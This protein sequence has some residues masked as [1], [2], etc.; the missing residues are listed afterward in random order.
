MSYIELYLPYTLAE[1]LILRRS[2]GSASAKP[3][4]TPASRRSARNK[5]KSPSAAEDASGSVDSAKEGLIVRPPSKKLRT[6]DGE[7]MA[8]L[9]DAALQTGDAP[10]EAVDALEAVETPETVKEG[11]TVSV[12]V[13]IE[14][15]KNAEKDKE[16]EEVEQVE[17]P[18]EDEEAKELDVGE[19]MDISSADAEPSKDVEPSENADQPKDQQSTVVDQAKNVEK[20]KCVDQAKEVDQPKDVEESKDIEKLKDDKEITSVA[21]PEDSFVILWNVDKD[22]ENSGASKRPRDKSPEDYK[23]VDHPLERSGTSASR[24]TSERTSHTQFKKEPLTAQPEM[25]D[26]PR[27]P[28]LPSL[29]DI[30]TSISTTRETCSAEVLIKQETINA[31]PEIK[32][33]SISAGRGLSTLSDLSDRA[34]DASNTTCI[35]ARI[36]ERLKGMEERLEQT[37]ADQR[38]LLAAMRVPGVAEILKDRL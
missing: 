12:Q 35:L 11:D 2:T 16:G 32:R 9:V 33:G 8:M 25:D 34:S 21:Q 22:D 4:A 13:D 20:L 31:E 18:K 38:R 28:S 14:Q 23:V 10:G 1:L 27:L 17:E 15:A 26:F 29:P 3:K 19:P 7:G 30:D 6:D 5:R 24:E 37:F 36:S